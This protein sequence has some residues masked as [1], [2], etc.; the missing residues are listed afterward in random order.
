MINTCRVLVGMKCNFKCSYCCNETMPELMAKFKE[1]SLWKFGVHKMKY[2]T[3]HVSGGEPLI[4]QNI[5][6][7]MDLIRM[8]KRA[9]KKVYLYTNLSVLPLE[10]TEELCELV[11][12]WDIGVHAESKNLLRNVTIIMGL[13]AKSVQLKMEA[14]Q[15]QPYYRLEE[16]LGVEINPWILDDCDVSWREDWYKIV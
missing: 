3:Y 10:Y 2:D 1:I 7:T 16:E 4:P 11:D 12:G 9:G 13:G 5:R 14:S 8:L 6:T 15:A